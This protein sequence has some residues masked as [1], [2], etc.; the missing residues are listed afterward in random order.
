MTTCERK[1]QRYKEEIKT[2]RNAMEEIST[3]YRRGKHIIFRIGRGVWFTDQK[4]CR[5]LVRNITTT[6]AWV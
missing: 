1:K 2:K 6:L 3:C 4:K 5:P